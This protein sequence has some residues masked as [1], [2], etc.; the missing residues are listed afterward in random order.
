[1]TYVQTT[2]PAAEPLTLAEVN[3]RTGH[4]LNGRLGATTLADAIAA[5]LTD[6]GFHDFDVSGVSGD[7][8]GY[9]QGETTS[10]RALLSPLAEV[11]RIDVVEDAGRLTFRSRDAASLPPRTIEVSAEIEGEPPWRETRGHDS[12]FAAEVVLGSYNPALDYEQSSARSRRM[13]T[14]SGRILT[15]DVPAVLAEEAAIVAA[16]LAVRDQWISRRRLD[17]SLSPAE[18]EVQP[19]DPIRVPGVGGTFLVSR[20]EEGTVRRV[21][22]RQHATAAPPAPV[23]ETDRPR[24]DGTE[25]DAFAP[26]LHFLDLPRFASGSGESFARAAALCRPWQR[27]VLSSSSTTE[28][29]AFRAS[30]DRPA[31]LGRLAVP[32]PPGTVSGRFDRRSAIELE[33]FFGGL[34]SASTGAA[35]AG[36]NRVAIRSL[37]GAWEIA[38][39]VQAE[40][41]APGRWRLTVLLRGLA[42]TEDAMMA[43]AEAGAPVVVLDEAVAPLGLSADERGRSLNWLGE[44]M[45]TSGARVGPFSFAG[46]LRAETP[47]APVHLRGRREAGGVH[48]S[49][50]RRGRFE[51]DDWEASEIPLDEP[52][53]RY[54]VDI[55]DGVEV[56]R[57][58]ETGT[59]AFLYTA[60]DEFTD[61]GAPQ[62][63]LAIRVRQVGR[64]VPLGLPSN[65]VISLDI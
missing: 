4:W 5:I 10:A 44:G 31:R 28:G 38:T 29:Y 23:E 34:F 62:Q 25:S 7:L 37:A 1:M 46:G 24:D 48:L 54:R 15:Y 51:A 65:A 43:G 47:L 41:T 57:T 27:I 60:A 53:E 8:V 42:G 18:I 35:L 21:E 12:D 33:L 63:S 59:P 26:V 3:W 49:W 55:L 39:F 16:E 56:R 64:A 50:V 2:P 36:A 52:E 61:F 9:V 22:A 30:L 17:F 45:A 19:G 20:V 40:E 58:A 13:R 32:L 11:F 6:H 14:G